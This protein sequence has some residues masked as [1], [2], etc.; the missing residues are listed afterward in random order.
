MVEGEKEVYLFG[1][2]AMA[3][4][5]VIIVARMVTRI[6]CIPYSSLPQTSLET[7]QDIRVRQFG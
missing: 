7:E 2:L 3:I 6:Q 5:W 1:V 4:F